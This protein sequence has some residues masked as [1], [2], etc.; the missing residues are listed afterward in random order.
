[1]GASACGRRRARSCPT[2]PAQ[3]GSSRDHANIIFRGVHSDHRRTW[4]LENLF[5]PGDASPESATTYQAKL[6][7]LAETIM[8]LAPDVLAVQE[9]GGPEALADLV[10]RRWHLAYRPG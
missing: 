7:A 2:E 6:K 8:E 5:R 1:M 3:A 9:V 4:N 10:D